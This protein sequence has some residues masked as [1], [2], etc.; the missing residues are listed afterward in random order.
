LNTQAKEAVMVVRNG[1]YTDQEEVFN[2]AI[3]MGTKRDQFIQQLD[4]L[5]HSREPGSRGKALRL[6]AQYLEM[7]PEDIVAESVVA[8]I[9]DRPQAASVKLLMAFGFSIEA[10]RAAWCELQ[11]M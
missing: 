7:S 6:A 5:L 8:W 1:T 11:L 10:A 4:R 9:K 3:Q 2:G